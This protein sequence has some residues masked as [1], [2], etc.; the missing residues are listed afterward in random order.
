MWDDQVL[1][2]KEEGR[3]K[4]TR[5]KRGSW[6]DILSTRFSVSKGFIF[7]SSVNGFVYGEWRLL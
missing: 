2:R 4:K 1:D 5:E 7:S 6:L 3:H